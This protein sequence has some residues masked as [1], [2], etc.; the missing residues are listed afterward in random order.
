MWLVSRS[1]LPVVFETVF[2]T[3]AVVATIARFGKCSNLAADSIADGLDNS[4]AL[5]AVIAVGAEDRW[6]SENSPIAQQRELGSGCRAPTSWL[7][8]S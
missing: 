1:T 8:A 2:V 6:V 4:L 3:V 7:V 5:I